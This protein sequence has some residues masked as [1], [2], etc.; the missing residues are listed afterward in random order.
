MI[1][2]EIKIRQMI[3]FFSMQY[4]NQ[5]KIDEFTISKIHSRS[6]TQCI[7]RKLKFNTFVF[8]ESRRYLR[9]LKV[10]PNILSAEQFRGGYI[11]AFQFYN[12]FHAGFCSP[13]IHNPD[14]MLIVDFR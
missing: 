8:T 9:G 2:N 3:H 7:S 1:F 10:Q 5:V 6:E 13:Y 11:S 12:Q 14:Y 4:S